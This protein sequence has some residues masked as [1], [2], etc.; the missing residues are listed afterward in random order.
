MFFQMLFG[1]FFYKLF[2]ANPVHRNDCVFD[3]SA[4]AESNRSCD[5]KQCS[6]DTGV[7]NGNRRCVCDGV[8]GYRCINTN[9]RKLCQPLPA[10]VNG[11][12][13]YKTNRAHGAKATYKC[14]PGYSLVNTTER[15]CL[16]D[17]EWNMDAAPTCLPSDEICPRHVHVNKTDSFA[18][19]G[20]GCLPACTRQKDCPKRTQQICVCRGA[21]GMSCV[22]VFV[23]GYCPPIELTGGTR[24]LS[25]TPGGDMYTSVATIGCDEGYEMD[26]ETQ[27]ISCMINGQWSA[28][29]AR[30]TV[31]GI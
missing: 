7:C 16:G 26:S 28:Q 5:N 12:V 21:C 24:I 2:A 13:V 6:L 23:P 30:C 8:C 14:F 18:G 3:E 11:S 4:A 25:V 10:P 15:T 27:E 9:N 17:G 19:N 29:P 22:D 20:S 31:A 1:F